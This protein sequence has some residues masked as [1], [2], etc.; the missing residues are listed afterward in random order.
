MHSKIGFRSIEDPRINT[1]REIRDWFVRGDKQKTKPT[2]WISSQ[3]QFDLILSIDG[4]LEMLTF[5]LRKYPGSVIQ[6]RRISQDMLEGLFGT[7]RQL[8]GDSS[9]QTLK[10][11]GHSLNKYQVTALVS[12]EL[13]SINYGE[14]DGTGIGINTLT[15]R[16]DILII[17]YLKELLL[18]TNSKLGIIVE[19]K[20]A[21]LRMKTLI[22][23]MKNIVFVCHNYHHFHDI[24][25][26][27]FLLMI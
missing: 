21:Q 19:I 25:L 27:I 20:N 15:R 5:F 8:G 1:L 26:K 4:F 7:I 6:P 2:Q 10:S 17:V 3:C 14:A 12:S 13:K 16:Y 24:F 9:T 23:Y 18:K 11:Y 22:I